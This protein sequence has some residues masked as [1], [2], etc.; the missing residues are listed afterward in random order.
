MYGGPRVQRR[1]R[2]PRP[3]LPESS[4]AGPGRGATRHL[5]DVAPGNRRTILEL[6]GNPRI[7]RDSRDDYRSLRL[8]VRTPASHVG[9]RGSSPLGS[10]ISMPFRFSGAA[11]RPISPSY[12]RDRFVEHGDQQPDQARLRLRPTTRGCPHRTPNPDRD[13]CRCRCLDRNR[14]P[15]RCNAALR[16]QGNL[17]VERSITTTT[18]KN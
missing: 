10:A 5:S 1:A 6:A 3:K 8:A 13:R 4:L 2:R 17:L 18:T 9:N 11:S 16:D 15:N 7:I 14:R 12:F